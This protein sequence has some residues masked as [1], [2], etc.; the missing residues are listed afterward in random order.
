MES[1][2]LSKKTSMT[3]HENEQNN[4]HI[5]KTQ[6]PNRFEEIKVFAF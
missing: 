6:C 4:K 2:S 3:K 5:N 1:K